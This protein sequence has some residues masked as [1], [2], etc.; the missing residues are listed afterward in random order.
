MKKQTVLSGIQPSGIPT[1][2]NY[3]G[4]IRNWVTL[5][6]EYS[7]CLFSIVDLHALT[8]PQDPKSLRHQ[9]YLTTAILIAS[10]IDPKKSIIFAQSHVP[11]HSELGWLMTTQA[12]MGELS[13][14]TQFKD[15]SGNQKDSAGAGLF[16]Y[17]ALM[18]A[19]IL[20][21]N[22]AVVPTGE[23]QKQH[24]ELA[25]DLAQRFNSRYGKTF[26]VPTPLISKSGARIMSLDNPEQKMSKS[27][28]REKSYI[29]ITDDANTIRKKIMSATTDSQSSIK[30][31]ESRKGLFNLLTIYKLL[32]GQTES[33]IE[34]LFENQGYGSFKSAL[35]DLI[36]EHLTPIQK[37][38]AKLMKDTTKLDRILKNGAKRANQLSQPTLK[39]A[40]QHLGLV[41]L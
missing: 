32:S 7:T 28:G 29:L 34:H 2:G 30:F 13:R 4:A 18:A 31:D 23:D 9:I 3:L 1:L 16:T 15:K 12:N 20:L 37:D 5:Q 17:P 25:R 40:Q 39:K 6:E 8:V 33:Q 14:M 26:T 41:S 21:Y 22:T 38:V 24:V 27:S 10:G 19:D 11:A 36:I 35:A